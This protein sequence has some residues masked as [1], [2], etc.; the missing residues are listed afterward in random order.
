MSTEAVQG[1]SRARD[2]RGRPSHIHG[3]AMSCQHYWVVEPPRP[4]KPTC[5]GRC[6]LCGEEREFDAVP[7][8]N[9]Y[10]CYPTVIGRA[11]YPLGEVEE[12]EP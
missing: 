9:G 4:G 10:R 5:T 8:S 11:G 1:V 3:E 2:K 6:K 12:Y 7:P